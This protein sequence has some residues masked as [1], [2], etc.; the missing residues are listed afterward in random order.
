[1]GIGARQQK[2]WLAQQPFRPLNPSPYT[3]NNQSSDGFPRNLYLHA[4]YDGFQLSQWDV[5]I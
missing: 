3:P 2:Q 4:E 5:K 1:M